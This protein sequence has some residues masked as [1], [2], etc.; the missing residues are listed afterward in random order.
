MN[1]IHPIR[2][3]AGL[4]TG[5]AATLLALTAASPAALA[6][7]VPPPGG[8]AGTV[9]PPPQVHAIVTG[10]M[11]GWQITLIALA[12]AIIAAAVAVIVDRAWAAR[13]HLPARTA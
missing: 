2:R 4:L 13:R 8:G 7:N 1:H 6:V 11:P 9:Q 5:L 12:A 10:G 3:L